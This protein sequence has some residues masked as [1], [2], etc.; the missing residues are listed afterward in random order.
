MQGPNLRRLAYLI[1][2]LERLFGIQIY[3]DSDNLAITGPGPT[4]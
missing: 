2:E 1:D 4:A 3:I